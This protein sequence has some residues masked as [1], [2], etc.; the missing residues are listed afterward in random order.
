MKGVDSYP[1]LYRGLYSPFLKKDWL[2]EES[3]SFPVMLVNLL[4]ESSYEALHAIIFK[5]HFSWVA[6]QLIGKKMK[7]GSK[8]V[9]CGPDI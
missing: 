7:L 5:I 4:H 1:T 6:K 2:R 3:P 9:K 8:G